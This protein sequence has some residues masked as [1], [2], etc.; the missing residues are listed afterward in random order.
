M[1]NF[2]F[3]WERT[4][5]GR[6]GRNKGGRNE[7]SNCTLLVLLKGSISFPAASKSRVL[8]EFPKVP[9]LLWAEQDV[10]GV[11]Q[12][13]KSC[14]KLWEFA[15]QIYPSPRGG[16]RN[17]KSHREFHILFVLFTLSAPQ[18]GIYSLKVPFSGRV[19]WVLLIFVVVFT[20]G[21][22]QQRLLFRF[23]SE[24]THPVP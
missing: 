20:W 22:C 17:I 14:S 1:Q 18:V 19:G 6:E 5:G 2:I 24:I 10:P 13:G 12:L 15:G 11:G 9:Q 16:V 23:S 21:F 3:L 7:Y 4:K 8:H